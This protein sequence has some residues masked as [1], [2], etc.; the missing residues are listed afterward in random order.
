MHA[1]ADPRTGPSRSGPDRSGPTPAIR[2]CPQAPIALRRRVYRSPLAAVVLLL[3]ATQLGGHWSQAA[4][5]SEA[6][7]KAV[8]LHRFAAYVEWPSKIDPTA[9]FTIGVVGPAPVIEEM[10]RATAPLTIDDRRVVT[11]RVQ[12][13]ADLDDL[14]ILYVAPGYLESTRILIS[15]L[16]TPTLVVTDEPFGLTRGGMINFVRVGANVRFEVSVIAAAER[17]LRLRSGLLSI[18][19]RVIG[20]PVGHCCGGTTD[21]GAWTA[22]LQ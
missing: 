5:Y 2:P 21:P 8:Y 14:R 9:S 22:A 15:S 4:G 18:A 11:R 1:G 3:L 16:A 17:G 10:R 20:Q 13:P 19:L 6:A 7:L 12:D